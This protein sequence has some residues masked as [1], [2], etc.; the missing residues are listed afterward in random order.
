MSYNTGLQHSAYIGAHNA[1]VNR[2]TTKLQRLPHAWGSYYTFEDDADYGIDLSN[3]EE[4]AE[5]ECFGVFDVH[6]VAHVRDRS[7]QGL[8]VFS[9]QSYSKTIQG[10][11]FR[12]I[13]GRSNYRR[14]QR[15][16]GILLAIQI[17]PLAKVFFLVPKVVAC[18]ILV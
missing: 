8:I 2:T 5:G 9:D 16:M 13:E 6:L 14:L 18:D 11:I 4:G 7:V 17:Y 3:M 10:Y 15:S 12:S 1:A